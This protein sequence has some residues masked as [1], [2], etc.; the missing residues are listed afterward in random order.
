M[1]LNNPLYG[2]DHPAMEEPQPLKFSDYTPSPIPPELQYKKPSNLVSPT[3]R[4]GDV[5]LEEQQEGRMKP[6][7]PMPPQ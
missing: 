7:P 6:V 3:G 2:N 4:M 5:S 1:P